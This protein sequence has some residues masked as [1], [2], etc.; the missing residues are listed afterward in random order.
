[1]MAN[2]VV[3]STDPTLATEQRF[4]SGLITASLISME[5]WLGAFLLCQTKPADGLGS[6]VRVRKGDL[7]GTRV[8][9]GKC[10][11]RK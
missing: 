5:F 3:S 2:A 10:G 9:C 11:A 1:M 7:R 8:K 4:R 6:L